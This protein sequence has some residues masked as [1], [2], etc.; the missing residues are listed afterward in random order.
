MDPS[1]SAAPMAQC[2]EHCR[3]K[4]NV[5]GSIRLSP[6]TPDIIVSFDWNDTAVTG[7]SEECRAL[8]TRARRTTAACTA[9][10]APSTCTT[11]SLPAVPTSRRLPGPLPTGNVDVA[12]TIAQLLGVSL[13]GRPGAAA[14]GGPG[15]RRRRNWRLHGDAVDR[16]IRR[17]WRRA[18]RFHQPT[19]LTS[20]VADPALT[21]GKY[22]IDL[23][24]KTLTKGTKS[25]I[26]FDS[27]KA[28]RQ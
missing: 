12:P 10:S 25:W 6:P 17:R 19:N 11:R 26:Y 20:A 24:I 15:R 9:A 1:S 27:A 13:P 23:K 5:E 4:I 21:M 8:N 16:A 18:C 2:R 7:S 22:S 28:T 14:P 3:S